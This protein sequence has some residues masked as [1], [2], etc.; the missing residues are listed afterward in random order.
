MEIAN[1]IESILVV[2][3]L[4]MVLVAFLFLFMVLFYQRHL[5]KI[6]KIYEK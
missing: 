1:Q 6:K 5:A 2:G 4:L 3:T